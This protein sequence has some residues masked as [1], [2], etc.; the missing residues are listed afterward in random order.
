MY[1]SHAFNNESS[2][3][4]DNQLCTSSH[5]VALIPCSF[6]ACDSASR[7][8]AIE[9]ARDC[10]SDNAE[11]LEQAIAYDEANVFDRYVARG[12][13]VVNVHYGQ[14]SSNPSLDVATDHQDIVV[15]R[16]RR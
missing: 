15:A 6:A 5:P 2:G 16:K 13:E 12:F 3:R 11:H 14:W 1:F 7:S 4:C 8:F 9:V 10:C